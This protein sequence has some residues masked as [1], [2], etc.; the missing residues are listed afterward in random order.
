[1]RWQLYPRWQKIFV[2]TDLLSVLYE[3]ER[4]EHVS[5]QQTNAVQQFN[6]VAPDAH[7]D[8]VALEGLDH[9][10]KWASEV[11]A[12]GEDNRAKPKQNLR[13]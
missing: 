12:D 6:P 5:I 13:K 1:M 8:A 11:V 9:I 4:G 3:R 10:F 7:E 2:Q